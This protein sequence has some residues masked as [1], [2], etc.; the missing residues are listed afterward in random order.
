MAAAESGHPKPW[1]R[2]TI[3][4]LQVALTVAVVPLV[5]FVVM[6]L[7]VAV[8]MNAKDTEL[9]SWPNVLTANLC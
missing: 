3:W 8:K 9:G 6:L 2:A 1:G 4:L 7:S 5:I